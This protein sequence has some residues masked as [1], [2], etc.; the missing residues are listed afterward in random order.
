MGCE[1]ARIRIFG[2]SRALEENRLFPLK[3]VTGFVRAEDDL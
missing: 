2:R 3:V 1:E